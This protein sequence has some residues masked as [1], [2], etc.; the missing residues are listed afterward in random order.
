MLLNIAIVKSFKES[1]R[2]QKNEVLTFEAMLSTL[3]SVCLKKNGKS[4][5]ISSLKASVWDCLE[6]EHKL[7]SRYTFNL[8]LIV[9]L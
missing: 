4:R 9:E 5:K 2:T 3:I 7:L 1:L 6:G 8:D